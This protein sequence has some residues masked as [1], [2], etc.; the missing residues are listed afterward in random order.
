MNPKPSPDATW[1]E[2]LA[3]AN[4][5]LGNLL[6]LVGSESAAYLARA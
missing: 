5:A 1:G 4:I 3:D 6:K 2:H